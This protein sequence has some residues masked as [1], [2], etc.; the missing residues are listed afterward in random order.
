MGK[1]QPTPSRAAAAKES[2]RPIIAI[3]IRPSRLTSPGRRRDT[4]MRR[5]PSG[6]PE[7]AIRLAANRTAPLRVRHKQ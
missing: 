6:A 5:R 2:E 3:S 1:Q 4:K 7:P